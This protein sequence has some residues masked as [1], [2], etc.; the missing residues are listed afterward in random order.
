MKSRP[1]WPDRY[2]D[3]CPHAGTASRRA[4]HERGAGTARHRP[5]GRIVFTRNALPAVRPV[6]HVLDAGDIVVR[7]QDDSTLAALH[8][9]QAGAGV[10]VAYEADATDPRVTAC[11]GHRTRPFWYCVGSSVSP[12]RP[13]TG[14]SAR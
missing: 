4:R 6:N 2:S 14:A 5:D 8:T 10:V 13:P 1:A 12:S 11:T 9:A 3:A 7:V